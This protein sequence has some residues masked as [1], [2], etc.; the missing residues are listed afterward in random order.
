MRACIIYYSFSGNTRSVAISLKE[1]LERQNGVDLIELKPKDEPK[2]F[3]AQGRSAVTQK[4]IDLGDAKFDLGEYDLVCFGTP[5]WAFGPT[6][7]LSTYAK[8][9]FG[10]EGKKVFIFT[11]SGGAG[12]GRCIKKLQAILEEKKASGFVFL[13][14]PRQKIK[15]KAALFE[16]FSKT[17]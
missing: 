17:L 3:F 1:Y 10:L 15:Y 14:V 11:T 7:A 4:E 9:C 16:L 5:V 6:P 8:K 13:A 2:N 12:D